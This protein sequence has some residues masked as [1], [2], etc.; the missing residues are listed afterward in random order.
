MHNPAY[1]RF[2]GLALLFTAFVIWPQ[3]FGVG[4]LS[5]NVA[6]SLVSADYDPSNNYLLL[7][8]N[9]FQGVTASSEVIGIRLDQTSRNA[10]QI[11][12]VDTTL[13][14]NITRSELQYNYIRSNESLPEVVC[15]SEEGQDPTG[16]IPADDDL[17]RA[18]RDAYDSIISK[19]GDPDNIFG[20]GNYKLI[21]QDVWYDEG[22]FGMWGTTRA[23]V[24]LCGYRPDRYY[25]YTSSGSP[26]L[27][28]CF[29]LYLQTADGK[30]AT[31][32]TEICNDVGAGTNISLQSG[33]RTVGSLTYNGWKKTYWTPDVATFPASH[34]MVDRTQSDDTVVTGAYLVSPD[35]SSTLTNYISMA[36]NFRA[37]LQSAYSE[38]CG[39]TLGGSNAASYLFTELENIVGVPY[40]IY[41]TP[42]GACD[43]RYAQTFQYWQNT[44]EQLRASL[45]SLKRNPLSGAGYEYDAQLPTTITL[46]KDMSA[47]ARPLA[48][49]E[50]TLRLDAT[51]TGLR[52]LRANP[53]IIAVSTI[54]DC[55]DTQCTLSIRVKNDTSDD[56]EVGPVTILVTGTHL[57]NQTVVSFTSPGE[58]KDVRIVIFPNNVTQSLTDNITVTATAAHPIDPVTHTHRAQISITKVA[59]CTISQPT[60]YYDASQG[61]WFYQYCENIYA[62]PTKMWCETGQGCSNGQGCVDDFVKSV[63]CLDTRVYRVVYQF[64]GETTGVCDAS[65]VCDE[66]KAASLE[67]PP[68]KIQE[69]APTPPPEPDPDPVQ[70]TYHVSENRP[71]LKD[72]ALGMSL[73]GLALLVI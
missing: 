61:K 45:Y 2:V 37:T 19:Y 10:H 15:Y 6:T 53:R 34:I 72:I 48:S 14:A 4:P 65:Y 8:T 21:I 17:A 16:H 3:M 55:T 42:Y 56:K 54:G 35:V 60:C 66:N 38:S 36:D 73:I 69:D 1:R 20:R 22:F 67:I 12:V 11:D 59:T 41:N 7:T 50:I 33:G 44:S 57:H 64:A 24:L 9:L 30:S 70:Y 32:S 58:V 26:E 29:D 68:C 40:V 71:S 31:A 49:H 27:R 63:S 46:K 23:K 28:T 52:Y 47:H 18:V 39:E 51:F 43:V 62:Q 13:T 25:L 5:T